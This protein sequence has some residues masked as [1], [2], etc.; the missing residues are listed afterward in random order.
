MKRIFTLLLCF[1]GLLS[2]SFAKETKYIIKADELKQLNDF[3]T[4]CGGAFWRNQ[5]GWPL[6]EGEQSL[7]PS[8]YGIT[9][10]DS[11]IQDD[12]SKTVIERTC[13][14]I[15]LRSNGLIGTIPN[16]NL[17]NL[18]SLKLDGNQLND[19]IPNFNLQNLTDLVLSGNQLSGSIP[20]FNLPSL[21]TLHL[22]NNQLSGAI[23]NFNLPMLIMLNFA[24]NQLSGS[25]PNFNLPNLADLDLSSNKL[26]GTIPDFKFSNLRFLS[27][28]V[29]Q[30]SGSIPNF[31]LPNLEMLWLV[32]NKLSGSIPNFN[33]PN[34]TNIDL[35]NNQLSGSIPDFNL[36]KLVDLKLNNNQ[37]SGSIPNFSFPSLKGLYLSNN[38]LSGSIPN[39]NLPNLTDLYIVKNQLSG[40]IPNFNLP[41]LTK[42]ALYN[43]RLTFKELEVYSMFEN[44]NN[45]YF[46]FGQDTI[47]PLSDNAN[48][49]TVQT[50][51]QN[52]LYT[53]YKDSKSISTSNVNSMSMPAGDKPESY[54]CAVNNSLFPNLTLKTRPA[55]IIDNVPLSS[56]EHLSISPNPADKEISIDY[57]F[58]T[59][60]LLSVKLYNS[61]GVEAY[62][63]SGLNAQ[64]LQK[65]DVSNLPSG[66]YQIVFELGARRILYSVAVV[67]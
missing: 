15:N 7:R 12:N 58:E 32:N 16:F 33:L 55:E 38:K 60:S 46:Y 41:N 14:N 24:N 52:N 31:N 4:Q 44:L 45:N 43:N 30:L 40:A 6:I 35:S 8:P 2:S 26:S 59:S 57:L 61:N 27:L 3:Y 5:D 53:W 9:F 1:L 54:Y 62:N 50:E 63:I 22:D 23:P 17:P 49:L 10:K 47:L 37:L 65:I 64:G 56:S 42:L 11:I 34:L 66:A 39:F 20:D 18:T 25:I 36:P 21:T 28:D 67:K 19:S 51:G 29:N 13:I 48:L